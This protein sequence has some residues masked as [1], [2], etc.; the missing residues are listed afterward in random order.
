MNNHRE[1]TI[2]IMDIL[3]SLLN[4]FYLIIRAALLSLIFGTMYYFLFTENIYISESKIMSSNTSSST[5]NQASG[6]A[7]QFGINI[8]KGQ[9]DIKYIYP[10][11][12]KSRKIA[13]TLLQDKFS[14]SKYGF[15]QTLYE[16][17]SK[18]QN[19]IILI[20]TLK[21]IIVLITYLE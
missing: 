20:N 11:L 4:N 18:N 13:K 21:S 15:D 7:A 17:L 3:F 8:P 6:I 16:I 19:Q 5:I 10:E 12:V 2:S 14:T 1:K 9:T